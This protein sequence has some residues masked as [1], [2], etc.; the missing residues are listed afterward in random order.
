MWLYS[1]AWLDRE[2]LYTLTGL[3]KSAQQVVIPQAKMFGW[4]RRKTGDKAV[5]QNFVLNDGLHLAIEWG[6]TG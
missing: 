5:V 6:K 3:A 1:G 2:R 4:L